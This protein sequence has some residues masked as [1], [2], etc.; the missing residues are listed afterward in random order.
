MNDKP[1]LNQKQ[2]NG[3]SKGKPFYKKWWFWV[4]I[5]IV[6]IGAIGNSAG[7]GSSSDSSSSSSNDK[8]TTSVQSTNKSNNKSDVK[9]KS[10][11]NTAKA[12]TLGAGTFTV[13]KDIQPGRYV[14]KATAGS[15]NLGSEGGGDED[16]NVILGDTVDNDLGQV[17]SYT[18]DLKK[19]EKIE[20]S[21]IDQ[22]SFTP[23]PSSRK[24]LTTLSAGSW[25]VGKD[26]KPGRY[27]I[28][29]TEGSGNLTSSNGDINEILGTTKDTDLGQVTEVTTDLSDG[30]ILNTDLQQI[31]L[32]KK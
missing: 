6:V 1:S 17:T 2:T 18:A 4:I 15:G 19:G 16:I 10:D 26:I 23:T 20:I 11:K 8:Q 30:Q 5:V 12:V 9:P 3:T 14:I 21:G 32:V 27:L 29:A 22:T 28:K 7:S 13:G 25:V 24:F 31:T